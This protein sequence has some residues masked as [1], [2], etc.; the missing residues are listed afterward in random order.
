MTQ[1]EK[2]VNHLDS[3][4]EDHRQSQESGD[5]ANLYGHN[6]PAEEAPS[7]G[8]SREPSE[9]ERGQGPGVDTSDKEPAE[10]GRDKA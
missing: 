8:A 5:S 6:D 3:D 7:E 10:G 4:L 2:P 1:P 9:N